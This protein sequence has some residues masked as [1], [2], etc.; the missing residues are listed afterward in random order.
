MEETAK[1]MIDDRKNLMID[2][3]HCV[4][5]TF[6]RNLTV[7]WKD[8]R[9]LNWKQFLAWNRRRLGTMKWHF[10]PIFIEKAKY[11]IYA[12]SN[13]VND[14][15][16]FLSKQLYPAIIKLYVSEEGDE[17]FCILISP[18]DPTLAKE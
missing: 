8:F 6:Q 10:D 5:L 16:V 18:K 15:Q 13:Y 12:F 17:P 3:L 2:V 14:V 1:H 11:I 4:G 9:L 7:D